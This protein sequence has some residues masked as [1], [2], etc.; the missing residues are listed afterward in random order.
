MTLKFVKMHG[1]G[2]DYI[3]IDCLSGQY[4][5]F[6]SVPGKK[7]AVSQQ[8]SDRHFGVGGDGLVLICPSDRADAQMRMFN[9]DG[10]EG[11]MCG[12]AIRCV[13][14]YLFDTG[15]VPKNRIRIDTK[16]G[17][18]ILD[19]TVRDGKMVA[20][21]VDMGPPRL[22]PAQLPAA[23]PGDSIIDRPVKVE[24]REYRLTCVSMGN[25][26]C[27]SFGGDPGGLDLPVLGGA[28][29]R[30]AFFP[31]GVNAEFAQVLSPTALRMR[32]WER[33]SGETLAC[34]TGACAVAVAAVLNGFCQRDTDIVVSL[35]GGDLTVRYTGETVYLTGPA[36][37][38]F[39]GEC[40]WEEGDDNP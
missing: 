1:C 15:K 39:A 40:N 4:E 25:P 30:S 29:E 27:V 8:L 21:R 17:V 10:S 22:S 20:A 23:L 33:G 19:L 16:S 12:N 3:Y 37:W 28:L 6:F 26:H 7:E 13:A 38:V 18:K 2:N 5:G 34:G 24:G 35:P 11:N 9:A 31:E 32:V 36:E 14:K